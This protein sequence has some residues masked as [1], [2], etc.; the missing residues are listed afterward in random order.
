MPNAQS[1]RAK[2]SEAGRAVKQTCRTHKASGRSV[3]K[4]GER[5]KRAGGRTKR[6]G[7]RTTVKRI[8]QQSNGLSE[9]ALAVRAGKSNGHINKSNGHINSQ[10]DT[11]TSQTDIFR[12]PLI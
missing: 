5:I 8:H 9:R 7:E 1:K 3:A 2:R 10:L 4:Q 11:S 12:P 6:A